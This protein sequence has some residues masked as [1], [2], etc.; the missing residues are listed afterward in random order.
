MPTIRDFSGLIVYKFG[1]RLTFFGIKGF[2]FRKCSLINKYLLRPT[3]MLPT[4]AE[5]AGP[6]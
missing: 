2:V 1:G 6:A 5:Q 3:A 4:L